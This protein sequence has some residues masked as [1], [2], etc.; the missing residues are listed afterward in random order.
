MKFKYFHEL[1]VEALQK[2]YA[3]GYIATINGPRRIRII[4]LEPN[5]FKLSICD[6]KES[7]IKGREVSRAFLQYGIIDLIEY[8]HN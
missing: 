1:R 5:R 2:G 8:V 4:G 6:A 3:A 7:F